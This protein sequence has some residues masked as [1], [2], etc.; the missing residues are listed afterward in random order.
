MAH[1]MVQAPNSY[2]AWLAP[3]APV[4]L[5]FKD[6]FLTNFPGRFA[7]VGPP[8]ARLHYRLVEPMDYH[9]R[10]TSTNW[11]QRNKR[12]D[13]FTFRATFPGQTNAW[14]AQ[15]RGTVVL[16][17]GYGVADYAMAP[18]AMQLAQAGWRCV[19]VDLRGHG[20]STGDQIYFGQKETRDLSQLLELLAERHQLVEPVAAVGESYGA[21]LALRWK[22]TEPRVGQIVA[23]APYAVLSNAVL[24]I[25][26]E[27]APHLPRALPRAGLKRLPGLL[28][29]AARDLD[30]GSVL[31]NHQM[32]ALFVVG[33][34]DKITTPSDVRSLFEAAA[35]G[36]DFRVVPAATHETVPYFFEE[37][38][39]PVAAW[40][41]LAPGG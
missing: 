31:A 6:D 30:T 4:L 20:E 16:L 40:L 27:Y 41:G 8:A 37:L 7:E 15:P 13:Q 18:W 22:A 32:A 9:F 2:P 33:N 5:H 24:N 10:V 1:R 34:C 19:L 3:K 11:L 39:A 29:V 28:E 25:C 17:H 35:P 26:R 23:I 36:S 12:R 21:S 38:A 14:T